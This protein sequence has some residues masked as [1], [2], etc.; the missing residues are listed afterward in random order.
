MGSIW[1]R[2]RRQRGFTLIELLAVMA[3]IAI[4][5]AIVA[6][7]VSGTKDT[8]TDSQSAQD[9]LQ[10]RAGANQYFSDQ[11]AVEGVET[12]TI[13]AL[14]IK[15]ATTAA[16]GDAFTGSNEVSGTIAA[17]EKTSSRWPEVFVTSSATSS[18]SVY[19]VELP[20]SGSSVIDTVYFVDSDDTVVGGQTLLEKY[21]AID[22][23]ALLDGNYIEAK[24]KGVDATRD[25]VIGN[26]TQAVH[27]LVWLFR[28]TSTPGTTDQT[29]RDVRIFKLTEA[30]KVANDQPT[31]PASEF[32]LTYERIF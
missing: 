13:S 16:D 4:L 3:I 19:Y 11:E 18:D 2:L 17:T 24:P 12:N 10:V 23:D 20:V 28:K 32:K 30:E 25:L 31:I 14:S 5:A 21:T 6:P 27:T 8:S 1:Q 22:F 26:T 29:G 9:A 7:A 15:V